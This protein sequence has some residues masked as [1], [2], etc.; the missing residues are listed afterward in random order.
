MPAAL[1]ARAYDRRRIP[2]QSVMA[3][4]KKNAPVRAL[5]AAHDGIELSWADNIAAFMAPDEA[6][7]DAEGLIDAEDH[8][9]ESKKKLEPKGV[10]DLLDE[11]LAVSGF[12]LGE[13]KSAGEKEDAQSADLE[14]IVEFKSAGEKLELVVVLVENCSC[15]QKHQPKTDHRAEIDDQRD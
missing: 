10:G 2:N 3:A 6:M 7:A 5:Q 12:E 11:R 14:R 9:Q 13:L 8:Q 4:K 1:P 15:R